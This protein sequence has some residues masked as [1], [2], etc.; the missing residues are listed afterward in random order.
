[1]ADLEQIVENLSQLT[2]IEAANLTKL[3]EEKWGVSATAAVVSSAQA[4][5]PSSAENESAVTEKTS[6]NVMLSEIGSKKIE[7][8]KAVRAITN[9]G[10]K[11]AK[12]LVDKTPTLLKEGVD[13]NQSKEI[14]EKLENAGAKV[15]IK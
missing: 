5:V 9:L 3:L 11:E 1:M 6:F 14:K 15:E 12:D 7:V 10:L 4:N 2:V 8:I 13:K